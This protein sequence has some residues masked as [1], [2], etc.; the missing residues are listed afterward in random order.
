[1]DKINGGFQKNYSDDKLTLNGD[2]S[3]LHD[4]GGDGV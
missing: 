4:D 1:M 3:S 2:E